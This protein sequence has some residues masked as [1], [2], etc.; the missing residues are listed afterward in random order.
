[1]KKTITFFL[2]LAFLF[3]QCVPVN[4]MDMA[5]EFLCEIGVKHYK[6]GRFFDALHELKKALLVNSTND[7][8][9]RYIVLIQRKMVPQEVAPEVFRPSKTKVAARK[10]LTRAVP[11]ELARVEASL[12]KP[13]IFVAPVP[14]E[15]GRALSDEEIVREIAV[16]EDFD[17]MVP[18]EAS[19]GKK[20]ASLMLVEEQL[21]K[22]EKER[23]E[24][25]KSREK[26]DALSQMAFALPAAEKWRRV[27]PGAE[28]KPQEL[29]LDDLKTLK[30]PIEIEAGKSFVIKGQAIGRFLVTQ[31]ENLLVEKISSGELLATG[32][33]FGYT[34]LHIWEQ[35]VRR[36][37]E[38]LTVAPKPSGPTIEEE[39][40]GAQERDK[41]FKLRYSMDWTSFD[42][43][44]RLN[45]LRQVTSTFNHLLYLDGETPYGKLDSTVAINSQRTLTDV[46]YYTLGLERGKIG[47]FKD[48]SLRG[49]DFTAGIYNL[50]FSSGNL[51]GI[52]FASPAFNHKFNYLLFH[53]REGGGRY[54]GFSPGLSAVKSSY[55]SGVNLNYKPTK[56]QSHNVSFFRGWGEE[57]E[58]DL[59]FYGFDI[60]GVF[61]F[62]PWG[63]GYDM[64]YDSHSYAYRLN[65]NYLDTRMNW[66]TEIRNI[67]KDFH[68]SSGL[69]A[70][71]GEFGL[72]NNLLLK[73]TEKSEVSGRLDIYR[74]RLF[75]NPEDHSLWN[76]DFNAGYTYHFDP[77]T[78][79]NTDYSFQNLLGRA[80]P[81]RAYIGGVGI[82]KV[83]D[84]FRKIS[85]YVRFNHNINKNFDSP[86]AS[87]KSYRIYSGLRFNVVKNIDYYF[88][89]EYDWVVPFKV[90][91]KATPRV[92][93]NGLSW[94]SRIGRSPYYG[95]L[96]FIYRNEENTSSAYSFLSGE[97]YIEY[98]GEL[99]YRPHPDFEAYLNTRA[100]NVWAENS[101]V[102]KRI[103]VDLNV[104]VR[105]L[106]DTGFRWESVGSIEGFVFKDSNGD[107]LK[108]KED[109]P[110]DG[111]KIWAGKKAQVTNRT[112]YYMFKKVRAAEIVVAI[113]SSTIP[114]GYALTSPVSQKI[115]MSQGKKERVD[116]GV[117]IRTEI[118]GCVF[119]DIEGTGSA[120]P[121]SA[122][123]KGV[124]FTLQDG[125]KVAT[126][127]YGR[128]V[129]K[130][131]A[132]G[133]YKATLDLTTVPAVYIPTV[134]VF[135][136]I[137]LKEG[138]SYILN[139]PLKKIK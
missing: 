4:A 85:T 25:E 78:S 136:E 56:S 100:R 118:A 99:S 21:D 57:R 39:M 7:E 83:W 126:D 23:S 41:N 6:D 132:A 92:Y 8:A 49:F 40:E 110:L 45:S 84:W 134:P 108:E 123:V 129:F 48:F 55:L 37:F 87:Y 135:K 91:E 86:S 105:Y 106:W 1:M 2:L 115:I 20:G 46:T 101:S 26:T 113:D 10:R 90:G 75:P 52:R 94:I 104:G 3:A 73:P 111:V 139:I 11:R 14:A 121:A 66:L 122:G 44:R 98:S 95:E 124:V 27:K 5:S 32:K 102:A 76:E 68:S 60:N 70:N 96:R 138:M 89:Q 116:F 120:G 74:N 31:P 137:E 59:R 34:Y 35:D 109:A 22:V 79:F 125:T 72:M 42:S 28:V 17:G 81:T 131:L 107:G 16:P 117:A 65:S 97:D 58:P 61:R 133:K 30:S 15:T 36:T 119:E 128:F 62:D 82:Y 24:E 63:F 9:R 54:G 50:S 69:G 19:S 64:A 12:S 67:R 71:A 33:N 127:D 18:R 53:G 43:G 29:A 51:R 47:G 93:E 80:S 114:S 88:N 103:D 77:L 38:F 112:G 130:N 13:A